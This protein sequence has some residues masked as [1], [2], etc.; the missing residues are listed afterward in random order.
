MRSVLIVS[1]QSFIPQTGKQ[2]L[3]ELLVPYMTTAAVPNVIM[4]TILKPMNWVLPMLKGE[5]LV[6]AK[7]NRMVVADPGVD[8]EDEVF[9]SDLKQVRPS[10]CL[11]RVQR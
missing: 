8:V 5:K 3:G 10:N 9:Q 7:E 1:H 11:R 4:M 2:L 6:P